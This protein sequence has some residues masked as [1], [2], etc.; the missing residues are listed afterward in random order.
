MMH[1][2]EILPQGLL[3]SPG[4]TLGIKHPRVSEGFATLPPYVGIVTALSNGNF[5]GNFITVTE[6]K[7]IAIGYIFTVT[8]A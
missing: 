5:I 2:C 3:K 8:E 4:S 6:A 7:R 1:C